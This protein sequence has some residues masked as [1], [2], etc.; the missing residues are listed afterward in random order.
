[1]GES[2]QPEPHRETPP[3]R[4]KA[5]GWGLVAI[6]AL[7]IV[8]IILTPT[9]DDW[10]LPS[11]AGTIATVLS[12]V[13]AAL[14]VWAVLIFGRGVTPSPMPSKKATLQTRGPYRWIRHPMY[15]GVILWMAGSA[16]ARANWLAAALW[17]ALVGF[18]LAKIS[19]EERRLVETYPGYQ[20]YRDSVPALVPIRRRND[21]D[22]Q[23]PG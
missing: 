2:V 4:N 12:V 15:T 18:F 19:W 16:M 1:M 7:L 9:S 22:G 21:S 8:G 3:A 20:E 14:V 23:S 11:T 13:G 17:V 10:P 5:V 6:Q